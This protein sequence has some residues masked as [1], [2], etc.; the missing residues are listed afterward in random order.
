MKRA[1]V[2]ASILVLTGTALGQGWVNFQTWVP[3][4][5]DAVVLKADG[6]PVG[7]GYW[8]QLY[9]GADSSSLAAVDAPVNF[10]AESGY[11]VAGSVTIPGIAPGG[12]AF[13][14]LRAWADASGASF[15]AAAGNPVGDIGISPTLWLG[16]TGNPAASPPGLP[17]NLVGLQG[18]QMSIIPEP[19]TWALLLLGLG[20]LALGCRKE[21]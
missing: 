9:A 16:A 14:Q 1:L 21:D 15:E 18:F 17:V 6:N 4:Q 19:T 13:V 7:A 3:G 11:V 5:V 10:V 20:A 2:L 8:A 12:S